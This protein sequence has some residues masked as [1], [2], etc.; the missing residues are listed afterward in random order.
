MVNSLCR[1]NGRQ[2]FIEGFV[3]LDES[4]CTKIYEMMI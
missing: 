2:G 1:G 4:D 3:K